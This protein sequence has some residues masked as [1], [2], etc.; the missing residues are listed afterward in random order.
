VAERAWEDLILSGSYSYGAFAAHVET[1]VEEVARERPRRASRGALARRAARARAGAYN[2]V[3]IRA[4][5]LPYRIVSRH[6][7]W[8]TDLLRRMRERR[9][10]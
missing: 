4:P 5:R 8:L 3:V 10:P 2:K 1:V 9:G 7:P 6:A